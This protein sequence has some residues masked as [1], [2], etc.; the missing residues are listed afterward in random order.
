MKKIGLILIA[1]SI[2]SLGVSVVS[3]DVPNVTSLGVEVAT[4]GR[5]LSITVRHS[6]PSNIHY[7]SKLEVKVGDNVEV[8]DLDPQSTTSFTEEVS[9]ATSGRV[10]VRAYCTLH[11]WSSWA[12]L[13]ETPS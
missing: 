10:E 6:S 3:A 12:S 4:D 8:V 5:T 7:I 13:G 11:G 1:L 2:L 9:I